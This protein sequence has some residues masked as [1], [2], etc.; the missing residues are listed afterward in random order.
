MTS[1]SMSQ[2]RGLSTAAVLGIAAAAALVPLNST[3][4]AVAL[5]RIAEDFDISSGRASLLVT[6]Y[7][8]A[9]LV[10]QPLAGRVSDRFGT[11]RTVHAALV[12]L[13]VASIAAAASTTFVALA[14]ARVVQAAFAAALSPGVQSLLRAETAPLDRGRSFGLMGS[15]LGAGAAGGPVVGG[16][17]TQVFGWQAIFL[18]NVPVAAAALATSVRIGRR[19]R[20]HSWAPEAEP[21]TSESSGRIANP[22][23][24]SAFSVQAFSTLAQYALLLL[25]PIL[26]DARGWKPGPIGLVL[27]ALTVGMIV[28]GPLGGRW[29]DRRGRRMPS[30]Y[31]LVA[32]TA[33]IAVLLVGGASVAPIVLVAAL[34]VFGFGLGAAVPNL[35]IVALESVPVARTG[36]AAGVLSM[37]RY[38]GSITTTV[39]ISIFLADDVSGLRAVLAIALLSMVVA[40]VA[41]GRFPADRQ[42]AH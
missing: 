32:A 23:F 25:T 24:V 8:V 2:E 7:L 27:A 12:G 6:A 31:G 41:A 39:A 19:T 42:G 34:A 16:V 38:V 28:M 9:M 22:F 15:V 10:G 14:I 1:A 36:S 5:P 29:G 20:P 3:M 30:Q 18:I 11:R 17:L 35:Q 40:I 26:L 4:I 33:S 37:S 21:A 13:I